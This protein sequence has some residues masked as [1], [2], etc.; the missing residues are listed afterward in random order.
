MEV[1]NSLFYSVL[2]AAIWAICTKLYSVYRKKNIEESLKVLKLEKELLSAMEE[3]SIEMNKS[4]FR[5]IFALS[6]VFGAANL[7]PA[8]ILFSNQEWGYIATYSEM[9]MWGVFIG[10]ACRFWKRHDDLRNFG[11]AME[12]FDIKI[13]KLNSK[14]K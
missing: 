4:S 11:K 10:L 13:D 3:S 8:T 1:A 12:R 5:M 7:L 9:I 2:G 6:I 14:L